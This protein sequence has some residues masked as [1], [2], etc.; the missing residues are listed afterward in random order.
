MKE[1]VLEDKDQLVIWEKL[2]ELEK[3]VSQ[4]AE[5]LPVNQ[6]EREILVEKEKEEIERQERERREL[7][8]KLKEQQDKI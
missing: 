6:E 3:E 4:D 8:K 7:D 1:D 5:D 2:E